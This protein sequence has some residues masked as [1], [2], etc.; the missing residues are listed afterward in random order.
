VPGWD[1]IVRLCHWS[2]AAL[3]AFDWWHDDGGPV[4]RTAGY[5]AVGVVLVRLTWAAVSLGAASLAALR[6]SPTATLAYLRALQQ[7]QAPDHVGHNPLGVWM[8]WL[9]WGLV[10]LLGLTGWMSRLDMFWG[11]DRVTDVHEW[12]ADALLG[13]AALHLAGVA[14]MS[15]L[16]RE[17][18]PAAMLT[19]RKRP[20]D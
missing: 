17:N 10:L 15:W 3:V 16:R 1:A 7:G 11:D 4:H 13:A 8:V 19:G 5:V 9:L 20:F 18:L 12:L 14:L 6:P 2:L